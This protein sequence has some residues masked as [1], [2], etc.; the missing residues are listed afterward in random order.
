MGKGPTRRQGP[1]K[2]PEN[3]RA[4]KKANR[5]AD[6]DKGRVRGGFH[7]NPAVYNRAD[8]DTQERLDEHLQG[9]DQ[10]TEKP[11]EDEEAFKLIDCSG[12]HCAE[13]R[14]HHERPDTPRGIQSVR[15]PQNYVGP[16]FCSIECRMYWQGQQRMEKED[17]A[18]QNHLEK[19][20]KT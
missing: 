9:G 1:G 3:V 4:V 13:R 12:P 19:K 10:G 6:P 18:T 15:V 20:G 14:I 17:A 5:D 8:D 16:A 7:T 2:A 11:Q